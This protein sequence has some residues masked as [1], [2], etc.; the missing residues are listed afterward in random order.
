MIGSHNTYT[1]L[2]STSSIYNRFTRFWR[3]QNDNI[4]EQYLNGIRFFDIRIVRDGKKWRVAHGVVKLQ[5]TFSNIKSICNLFIGLYKDAKFRLWLENGNASDI[6][7]FKEEI[8]KYQPMCSALLQ[9]QIKN[10][11]EIIYQA[12]N[13]PIIKE[14]SYEKWDTK[15]VIKN[16]F[17]YPIKENAIKNNPIITQEMINDQ[18]TIWLMDY[19]FYFK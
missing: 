19:A 16:V 15:S 9:S 12:D 3:C 1:Y 2:N 4:S 5:K 14:Y 7:L 8:K 10:T 11:G 18:N 13:L 17:K 6:N